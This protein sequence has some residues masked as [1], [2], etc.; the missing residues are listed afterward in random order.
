MDDVLEGYQATGKF[1]AENWLTV[2]TRGQDAGV[3]L[4]A[5]H[6]VARHWELVYMG[7]VPE[8]RGR[9]L[10]RQITEYAQFLARR[11]N[12]ERIV[13]AVDAANSPALAMYRSA[14]FEPWDC[15]TVYVRFS[16][17]I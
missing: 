12:V 7:L 4:L 16:R 14:G 15:R 13:L 9:G 10:G 5:D 17:T 6:P 1:R 8:G 11:Q 3:L 2:Q